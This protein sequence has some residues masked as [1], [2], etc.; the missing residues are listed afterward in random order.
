[1]TDTPTRRRSGPRP[2]FDAETR[3]ARKAERNKRHP[4]INSSALAW[5]ADNHPKIHAQAKA[6]AE[7]QVLSERGALPGDD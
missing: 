2:R 6:F 5:L 3:A 1:M 7:A 4:L